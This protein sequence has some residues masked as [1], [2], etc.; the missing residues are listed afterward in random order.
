[1]KLDLDKRQAAMRAKTERTRQQPRRRAEVPLT[2]SQELRVFITQGLRTARRLNRKKHLAHQAYLRY[3]AKN[4]KLTKDI[5]AELRTMLK[6]WR[7]LNLAMAEC[8]DQLRGAL[9]THDRKSK[10]FAMGYELGKEM[11]EL[12]QEEKL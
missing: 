5:K 9:V 6:T 2:A 1:M 3:K 7:E 11:A 12:K 10:Q 4:K 8:R